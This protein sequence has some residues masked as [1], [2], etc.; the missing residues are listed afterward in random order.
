[1]R[2]VPIRMKSPD[3][4]RFNPSTV[5][6]I[7]SVENP[8]QL[9]LTVINRYCDMDIKNKILNFY[10][11]LTNGKFSFTIPVKYYEFVACS[12]T[13]KIVCDYFKVSDG[14]RKLNFVQVASFD[15]PV[16]NIIPEV[17]NPLREDC[18]VLMEGYQHLY[19]DLATGT[20]VLSIGNMGIAT[21]YTV[22]NINEGSTYVRAITSLDMMMNFERQKI[23]YRK[24]LINNELFITDLEARI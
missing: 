10:L 18:N 12:Q 19:K 22:A 14:Q 2:P 7:H 6:S 11:E 8:T 23:Y 9:N 1:M 3:N 17:P 13:N 16:I 4:F 15:K 20:K 5:T 24:I 21:G